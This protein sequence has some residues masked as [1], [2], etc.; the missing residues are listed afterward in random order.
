MITLDQLKQ[1]SDNA[2]EL[3]LSKE[4]LLAYQVQPEPT[5]GV[6]QDVYICQ[7]CQKQIDR[8]EPLNAVHFSNLNQTM[9]SEYP[10]VQVLA[11]RLLSRLKSDTWATEA[12]DMLY[13]DDDNLAWA[14]ASG[15]HE[16]D[17]L[18]AVHRDAN[19]A[20]L[21]Q[22]DTIVLTKSLDVKGS[23]V[24]ARL[25]TVVRNIRLDQNDVNYVEGKIEGQSIMIKTIYVR[26]QNAP[27]SN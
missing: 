15:D 13:L 9:W 16:N 2:C 10:A 24:N 19:G 18:V 11:W 8:L 7:A 26:K 1:R 23:T 12:L 25:G 17:D 5:H 14:K 27:Q 21:E 3:C 20:V 4:D 6:D 22:G